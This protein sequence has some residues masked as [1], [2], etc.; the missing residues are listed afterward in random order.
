MRLG[1]AWMDCQNAYYRAVDPMRAMERRGHE[2]SWPSD[3]RGYADVRELDGCDVVHVYR[4]ISQ[5]DVLEHLK[6]RGIPITYDND[7]DSSATPKQSPEYRNRRGLQGASR[8]AA[9]IKVA[10]TA[11]VCTTTSE[12]LADKYRAAGVERVEV[13]GNYLNPDTER[14]ANRHAGIVIGW[15]AALEHRA[16]A[17]HIRLAEALEAVLAK[18]PEVRVECIG[19]NLGLSQRY[20]HDEFVDFKLLPRRIAGFDVGIAPLTDIPFNRS[21]SDIKVKEYAASGVPWVASPVGPYAG[22]G[23]DQGGILAPD[24]G[25]FEALDRLVSSRKERKRLARKARKWAKG[26][27]IDAVAERWERVFAEAASGAARAPAVAVSK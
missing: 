13:I 8:F 5:P 11:S 6:Q 25:W 4:R 7:D 24:D 26:Q 3:R 17:A 9:Q 22:L 20:R 15:I 18:H 10:R 12:V 27:T 19:V 16:D 23:E 21:R 14:P 2:V 1:V